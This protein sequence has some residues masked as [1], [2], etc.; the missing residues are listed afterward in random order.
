MQIMRSS[1][2]IETLG[3]VRTVMLGVLCQV[4]DFGAP[5]QVAR[6]SD[7]GNDCAIQGSTWPGEHFG[8]RAPF[9]GE[10]PISWEEVHHAVSQ[11]VL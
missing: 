8:V 1:S 3:P 10:T 5:E 4:G 11:G 2:E 9:P 7:A 6:R